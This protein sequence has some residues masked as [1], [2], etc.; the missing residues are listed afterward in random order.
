MEMEPA[1]SSEQVQ[2]ETVVA[3][4]RVTK[5]RE[6]YL[7]WDDYFMAVARCSRFLM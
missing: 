7:S 5:K 1:P 4:R 2:S 3:E 6:N